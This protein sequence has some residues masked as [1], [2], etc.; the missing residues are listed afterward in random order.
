MDFGLPAEHQQSIDWVRAV[1]KRP[2]NQAKNWGQPNL[3]RRTFS[4]ALSQVGSMR[5]MSHVCRQ[6]EPHWKQVVRSYTE[7]I[8]SRSLLLEVV[9]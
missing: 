2:G 3:M 5:P 8:G 1:S 9:G 4:A 7:W 6:R